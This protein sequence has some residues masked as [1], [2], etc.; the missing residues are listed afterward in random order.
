MFLLSLFSGYTVYRFTLSGS[1][2]LLSFILINT[3]I[4]SY[5]EDS[6]DV[7][8]R[9]EFLNASKGIATLKNKFISRK[10]EKRRLPDKH[11]Q[12]DS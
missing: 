1:S 11:R 8:D 9:N 5:S 10:H 6:I 12:V 3:G 7:I 2:V 4:I